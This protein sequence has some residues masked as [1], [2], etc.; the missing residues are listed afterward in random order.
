MS[1]GLDQIGVVFVALTLLLSVAAPPTA[2]DRA[3][4]CGPPASVFFIYI[5]LVFS[6]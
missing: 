2:D 5:V 6:P 3:R 4:R 1:L